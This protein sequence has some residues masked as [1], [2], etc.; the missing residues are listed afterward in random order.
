MH[1]AVRPVIIEGI[2]AELDC[3][4]YPLKREVGDRLEVWADLFKEGH[5]RLASVPKYREKDAPEWGETTIFRLKRG[6]VG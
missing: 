5:N 1:R 3:G 4:R 2:Y 6:G